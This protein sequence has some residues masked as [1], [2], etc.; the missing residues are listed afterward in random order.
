MATKEKKV[1]KV[2]KRSRGDR[3][4]GIRT[5]AGELTMVWA[6]ALAITDGHLEALRTDSGS[7]LIVYAWPPGEWVTCFEAGPDRE[8]TAVGPPPAATPPE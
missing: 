1:E 5:K 4:W 8:A 2:E 7:A 3:Y 6:D